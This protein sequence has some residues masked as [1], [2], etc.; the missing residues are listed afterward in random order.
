MKNLFNLIVLIVLSTSAIFAQTGFREAT[1][2]E[3]D[4]LV[5]MQP[6]EYSQVLMEVDTTNHVLTWA[7]RNNTKDEY[8]TL[9]YLIYDYSVKLDYDDILYY[10]LF[11]TSLDGTNQGAYFVL[12]PDHN[13][14][15]YKPQIPH[16][17]G[18]SYYVCVGGGIKIKFI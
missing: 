7:W 14:Y 6:Y 9:E 13:S 11:C 12:R 17:V 10:H 3:N 5:D 8:T 16:E 2:S 15:F 4:S 18:E 1:F